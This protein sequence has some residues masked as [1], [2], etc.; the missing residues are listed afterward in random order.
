MNGS[1]GHLR[2][3]HV[4]EQLKWFAIGTVQRAWLSSCRRFN[5]FTF[6]CCV[7]ILWCALI[8]G[9]LFFTILVTTT[10]NIYTF[11]L[12]PHRENTNRS[13]LRFTITN[14]VSKRLMC[15]RSLQLHLV[16]LNMH[17]RENRLM[18]ITVLITTEMPKQ[19]Q[20]VYDCGWACT[21]HQKQSS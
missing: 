16:R 5:L 15:I 8:L 21:V 4:C 2:D 17:C 18:A 7:R 11:S 9:Q 14:K 3:F 20:I 10:T 6:S 13:L 12:S 1:N 19:M